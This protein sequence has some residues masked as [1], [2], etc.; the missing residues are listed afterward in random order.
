MPQ[1]VREALTPTTSVTSMTIVLM[2]VGSVAVH[3]KER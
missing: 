3:A 2:L 1:T